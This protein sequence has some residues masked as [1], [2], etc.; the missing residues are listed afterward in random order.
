MKQ[1]RMAWVLL[2]VTSAAAWADNEQYLNYDEFVRQVEAGNI[3]SAFLDDFSLITGT[4][5]T[6]DGTQPFRSYGR[7]GAANDPLLL[8]LLRAHEVA[9]TVQPERSDRM[10]GWFSLF[11]LLMMVVPIAIL[12]LAV[13]INSKLNQV[14][15]NQNRVLS[16]PIASSRG[17]P[18]QDGY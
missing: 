16:S 4:M 10:G 2:L 17:N 7:M 5:R 9:I 13:V 3:E 1:L 6:S 15:A 11:G 8:R 12:V 18:E 14:L